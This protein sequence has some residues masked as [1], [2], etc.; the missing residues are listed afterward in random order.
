[1]PA[2]NILH[3]TKWGAA[4]LA[5][6]V[7]TGCSSSDGSS[8]GPASS[9]TPSA[10]RSSNSSTA[11]PPEA[12]P[13]P[14]PVISY[15]GKTKVVTLGDTEIRATRNSI[16]INVACNTTN[17][18]EKTRNIKVTVSVGDGKGWVTTNHFDFQQVPAGQTASETTL[19]GASVEGELPDDPKV[20]IDSVM[21]Y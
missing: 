15:L 14:S 18:T 2:R 17:T 8:S 9:L 16:G 11:A 20:Y 19:M 21:Y 1:M 13:D 4:L 10:P 12:S 7:L 5:T 3:S 6:V